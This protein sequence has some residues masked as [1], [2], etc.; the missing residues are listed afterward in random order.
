[1][2]WIF[3]RRKVFLVRAIYQG[4]DTFPYSSTPHF[5]DVGPTDFGF[6]WI[7]RMYELGITTGCGPQLFCPGE[8]VTR[9]QMAVFLIRTRYGATAAFDYPPNP[10]FLDV[11]LGAF[12]YEFIQ[13]MKE[14]NITSGCTATTYCPNEQVTR[15]DMAIF[16]MRA[17]FNQLLPPTEAILSSISPAAISRGSSRTYTIAGV[18]TSFVNG[19]TTLAPIPGIT[20]GTVVVTGPTT[21]TVQL[22]AATN[23]SPQPVSVVAIT[24]NA[25]NNQEAVLPN[26]LVIR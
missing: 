20:A 3:C 22:T 17:G 25:P 19:T 8:T 6:A 14:D 18:N 15:G 23:A 21:L 12:G 1:M 9:A 7:Q 10:F 4:S 13:R 26:S 24:G 16:I 5:N 2:P 11:P